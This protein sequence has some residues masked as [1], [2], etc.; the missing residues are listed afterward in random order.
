MLCLIALIALTVSNAD[1]AALENDYVRVMRNTSACAQAYTPGFGTRVIVALA[2]V[3]VAGS[4]GTRTLDRGGIAVFPAREAYTPPRGE[5]FEVA[6]KSDHPP[7]TAPEQWLEPVKNTMVYEDDQFRVFEERLAGGDT[8]ELHSHAQR[9]VVRLNDVQLTD[10]RFNPVP[11]PGTGIQVPNTVRFAEP[12]VHVVHNVSAAPL[13]NIVI[14][15]K[16]QAGRKLVYSDA[17]QGEGRKWIAEFEQPSA[18]SVSWKKGTLDIDAAAGATVWF[19]DRLSGEL[20]ITYDAV[21]ID[22]GGRNDRVSDLNCFWMASD[23]AHEGVPRRNGKFSSYDDLDLYYAGIGGHDNTTTRFRKYN[24]TGEK[25]VLREYTDEPHLLRG[26][27]TYAITVIVDGGR[28]RLYRNGELYF[29]LTDPAPLTRGY[30]GI[31]TTRSR[32]QIRDFRVYRLLHDNE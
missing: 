24:R 22:S 7:Y 1:T 10:P 3:E 18:S 28:T 6:F 31:R 19:A 21:V 12:V 2:H 9:V 27:T 32:L 20:M 30:F 23:A 25:P 15:C 4:G 29:D 11:K 13:F 16:P 5:Y 26:N 14:E 17:V 8:R